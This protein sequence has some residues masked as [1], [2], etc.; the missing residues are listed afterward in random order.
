MQ[1][2]MNITQTRNS[3]SKVVSDVAKQKKQVVI[4]RDSMPEAVL[5]PYEDYLASAKDKDLLWQARFNRLLTQGK[6]TFKIWAKKNKVNISK[7]KEEEIYD[8]IKK[9]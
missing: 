1:Q 4:I 2:I 8:L 9:A 7:L 6:Q 3:L 5:I